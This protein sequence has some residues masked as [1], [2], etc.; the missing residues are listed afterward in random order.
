VDSLADGGREV[1]LADI[2]RDN[3]IDIV[4][5]IRDED[6]IVWYQNAFVSPD[7]T[8]PEYE[9]GSVLGPRGVFT[10]YINSDSLLD[11]VAGGMNENVVVWFEAPPDPTAD[12]WIKHVVDDSLGGVKGVFCLDM[13]DDTLI[14]IVAAGR[15]NNDVVWYERLPL[16]PVAWRKHFIDTNLGGAVSVWCGDLVGDERPEVA[17]TAK[18]DSMV[19]IYEQPDEVGDTWERTVLDSALREA[20]PISADDFD[21]DGYTD[22]VAAGRA[23]Q[24]VAWYRNPGATGRAWHKYIIDD[25]AGQSMGLTTGDLDNDGDADLV[26]TTIEGFIAWYENDVAAGVEIGGDSQYTGR[27]LV[28]PNPWTR[29]ITFSLVGA[30]YGHPVRLRIFN[31]EG[32]QVWESD[33][34]G[35]SGGTLVFHWDGCGGEDKPLPAGVYFYRLES[36]ERTYHGKVVRLK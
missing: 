15:D 10:A 24:T 11:V 20:C 25:A 19:V 5:A 29:A 16:Y 22:I 35:M 7:E 21:E 18:I 33:G 26:V 8:W 9:I 1:A 31:P 13:N 34:V 6:R 14:D 23:A 28:S 2:D 32:K 4:A 36:C 30:T 27:L 3:R 12:A 17:V